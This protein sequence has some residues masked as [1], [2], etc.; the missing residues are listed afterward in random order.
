MTMRWILGL[1]VA[2]ARTRGDEAENNDGS[3]GGYDEGR[4][5]MAAGAPPSPPHST[6]ARGL[7]SQDARNIFIDAFGRGRNTRKQEVGQ[8][9][10]AHSKLR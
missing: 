2:V 7:I 8:K 10:E 9:H 5:R 4:M 6:P 1:R 3:S